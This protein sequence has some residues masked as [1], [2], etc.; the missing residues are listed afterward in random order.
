MPTLADLSLCYVRDIA[1]VDAYDEAIQGVSAV[2]HVASILTMDPDSTK[3]I[4]ATVA[5]ATSIL[6]ASMKEPSV[7][8]FVYISS[9]GAAT[10]LAPGNEAYVTKD[11]YNDFATNASL[12]RLPTKLGA[13]CSLT[14]RAK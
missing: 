7:K 5:G 4:P 14:W 1:A 8:S 11:T 9:L 6:N 2:A 10:M 13:A 3:V 12:A